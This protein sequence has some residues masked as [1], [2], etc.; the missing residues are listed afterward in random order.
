MK[1]NLGINDIA[2]FVL[3]Y[4]F[5]NGIS[6]SPLKLQ[7]LLYYIQ[8]WHLVYFDKQLLFE[9]KPQAWVNGPVYPTIYNRFKGI[10]RYSELNKENTGLSSTT[11]EDKQQI[12]DLDK[13]QYEFL[14]SIFHHY[15]MM[16]HDRLVFLTHAE[17]PWSEKRDGLMPFEPSDNEI[18]FETM[19]NYYNQRMI[20]NREKKQ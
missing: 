6:I 8:A 15:G 14:N 9:E 20:K 10:L 3:L 16:E 12:L 17:L 7:K 2:D 11:L 18:S 4:C 13:E 5:E 1:T 19:F